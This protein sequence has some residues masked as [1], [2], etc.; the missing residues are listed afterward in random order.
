MHY[1]HYEFLQ[2]IPGSKF[3]MIV[4]ATDLGTE[5][6]L[7][8]STSF[9]IQV[10][11]SHKKA[12]SFVPR[13][14]EPIKLKEDFRDYD[15]SIVRLQ[16]VSNIDN[17]SNS[18]NL[19]L[20]FELVIGTTEQTNKEHTFRYYTNCIYYFFTPYNLECNVLTIANQLYFTYFI[21]Y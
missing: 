16:A 7:S 4:S 12:P 11:E 9:Y 18:D 6:P 21:L 17:S 2:R 3:G 8:S 5:K 10:V 14:E 1:D 13:P 19:Y 15:A 20:T